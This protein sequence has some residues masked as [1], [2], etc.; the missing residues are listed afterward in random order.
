MT[1]ETTKKAV[2]SLWRRGVSYSEIGARHG[3]T[4]G[5]V[6]GIIHRY[7]GGVRDSEKRQHVRTDKL[8]PAYF[9]RGESLAKTASTTGIPASTLKDWRLGR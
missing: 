5:Q 6:A 2:L 3:L 7:D 1:C 9:Q 8:P 4:K